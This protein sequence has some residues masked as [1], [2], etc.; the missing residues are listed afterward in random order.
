MNSTWIWANT[1]WEIILQG[2]ALKVMGWLSYNDEGKL[3]Q[4]V[5]V[6]KADLYFAFMNKKLELRV[7]SLMFPWFIW[8]FF[9]TVQLYVVLQCCVRFIVSAFVY[10]IP[11]IYVSF[12]NTLPCKLALQVWMHLHI[13]YTAYTCLK[14]RLKLFFRSHKGRSLSHQ[15]KF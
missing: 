13:L 7:F 1:S 8:F 6:Y 9:P 2:L 3:L 10:S 11:F 12:K 5:D 15:G 4:F 14:S